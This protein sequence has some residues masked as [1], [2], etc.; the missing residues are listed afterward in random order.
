M[1][2]GST[3]FQLRRYVPNCS[4]SYGVKSVHEGQKLSMHV[5]FPG[6]LATRMFKTNLSLTRKAFILGPG[7]MACLIPGHLLRNS[8][9]CFGVGRIFQQNYKLKQ[10]PPLIK[11][12]STPP[13]VR[14]LV[15][16]GGRN[17]SCSTVIDKNTFQA[18]N[19]A[20]VP[21]RSDLKRLLGLAKGEK[22][23]IFG[24]ITFLLVSSTVTMAVPFCIGKVVDIINS[25]Y[26]DGNV[27]SKL[28]VMC[29]SLMV[30]FLIGGL[31]NCG[32]VYLIQ[33]SGQNIVQ[34]LREK[35]YSS[36][37]RQE[38]G[39][40][41]NTK[42]GELVNRLANDT[43]LIG[44]SLTGNI[45]DGL[46][47]IG[48]AVGGLAMMV[49]V[50]PQLSLASMLVVPPIAMVAIV[51]GRYVKK[52]TTDVQTSLA[53]SSNVANER[54]NNIRTVQS[55][56]QE[57]LETDLFNSKLESVL[58]LLRREARAKALFFGFS[59]FSGNLVV[60]SVFYY[61]GIMMTESQLTV[62]ELYTFLVYAVYVGI[63]MGGITTFY[64]ELMRGIGASTRVWEL[65]DRQPSIE[66][67]GGL[68]PSK[69]A[70]GKI[71]FQDI[72]FHYPTRRELNIFNK[73]CLSLDPG[74]ITALIGHSGCGKSTTGSLLLRFYDPQ[75]GS[76]KLDD[77]N[78]NCLNLSWL[79]QQF[80]IVSQEPIL[81]SSTIAE[82]IAYGRP[83]PSSVPMADIEEAAKKANAY[84]FIK[85][86]PDGF[87]TLVGERGVMLSGGQRQRIAIARAI[88]KDPQILILDEATSALDSESEHVV[89]EALDGVM[90][91][92]TVIIIAHRLSTIRNV[93]RIIVLNDGVVAEEGNYEELLKIPNGIFQKLVEQQ[94]TPA[95]SS[96]NE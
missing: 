26:K 7:G 69:K 43:A 57:K 48:Q 66:H 84:N 2:Y 90:A 60:L 40:F 30:I 14:T 47:S 70:E 37:L 32:R 72:V 39:F 21:H 50:S 24:A 25:A 91:G 28:N 5:S 78:I 93:D 17:R 3:T 16:R 29:Q 42:S 34:R 62:G 4:S 68:V 81:F 63:S 18:K 92:R 86:F 38:I 64:S 55:F 45:S 79:R 36:L 35:L 88:L 51:Y 8:A 1:F 94:T 73:L 13:L 58:S 54:F 49:Y 82:N 53:N 75:S 22:W 12:L 95:A 56:V 96:T 87:Q 19:Y 20:K 76:I 80:G 85:Y 23:K 83:D 89:Q 71:E 31:A 27:M 61:G 67:T 65:L 10:W 9:T 33:I 74:S 15:L 52:I 59:G 11:S 44:Q 6:N 41:D 77:Q 46:R